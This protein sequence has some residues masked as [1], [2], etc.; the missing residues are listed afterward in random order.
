MNRSV[1]QWSIELRRDDQSS[2]RPDDNKIIPGIPT[3]THLLF[4]DDFMYFFPQEQKQFR[5]LSHKPQKKHTHTQNIGIWRKL[6][7]AQTLARCM[8]APSPRWD[9]DQKNPQHHSSWGVVFHHHQQQQLQ[10]TSNFTNN[11][12]FLFLGHSLLFSHSAKGTTRNSCFSP[13]NTSFS[14]P[15]AFGAC[16]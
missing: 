10:W 9:D 7:Y 1:N 6:P 3:N 8:M 16:A 15:T 13:I 4:Q 14:V 2:S 12:H 11:K 5:S